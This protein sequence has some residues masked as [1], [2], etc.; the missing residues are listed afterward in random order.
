MNATYE[1]RAYWE[2]LLGGKYSLR[3]V[4]YQ[5][6]SASFNRLFYRSVAVAAA[7]ALDRA[8]VGAPRRVLDVGSGTG[9]WID[10]WQRRGA[11]EIIGLDL[12]RAAVEGLRERLPGIR[13]EQADV[14]AERLPGG[15]GELDAISAMSVLLHITDEERFRRAVANLGAALAPGGV[16]LLTEPVVVHRWWGRP[17]DESSNSKARPLGEWTDA[18]AAAGLRLESLTPA[19]CLLANTIDTRRPGT[20]RLAFRYWEALNMGVGPRERLGAVV[21]STLY[22][23]DRVAMRLARTGPSTKIVVAR[24]VS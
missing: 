11:G 6:L 9:Y 15:L 22:A 17:F 5:G 4:G 18:L 3:G 14:G 8:G 13:F 7:A 21:G 23:L 2:S 10:F 16:L 1:A 24:R 12:T 20:Y 19:T